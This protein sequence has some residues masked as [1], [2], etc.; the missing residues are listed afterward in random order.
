MA[1]PIRTGIRKLREEGIGPFTA[2]TCQYLGLPVW[3]TITSRYPTGTNVFEREWDLLI[4][5]DSGRVDAFREV[6]ESTVLPEEIGQIRSVGSASSEW[7]LQTFREEFRDEIEKTALVTRNGWPDHVLA[8]NLH[9][10]E[11]N[12]ESQSQRGFPNWSPVSS[13]A[14]AHYERIQSVAN[15]DD[16]IHPQSS[17]VPHI[18]TDRAISIARRE[19]F[20]RMILWYMMPHYKFIADA[21]DWTPGEHSIEELMDGLEPTRHLRPEEESYGPARRGE[22]S[23]E[24]VRELYVANLRLVLEYIEVLLENVDAERVVI[25]ADHGEAHGEKGVWS[26]PFG[27]P[28][29]PVKTVPWAETTATDEETYEPRYE[30]LERE[31]NQ[32][33]QKQIL[34][35]LGYL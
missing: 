8:E 24:K 30:A 23:A 2:R 10:D 35:D 6:A 21:L 31:V 3:N 33:E 9:N 5:L 15:Q 4:V 27:W 26:H 25:S 18:L 32:E 20:D 28:F 11:E 34:K 29:A 22:V 14:F 16:R 7:T 17:H 1:I 13:D 12:F 19:E